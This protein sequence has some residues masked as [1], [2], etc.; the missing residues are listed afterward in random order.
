[1]STP[2]FTAAS[3]VG[4]NFPRP[5][6]K[7]PGVQANVANP[8]DKVEI[9]LSDNTVHTVVDTVE[10]ALKCMEFMRVRDQWLL[11]PTDDI[12]I[13]SV[14]YVKLLIAESSLVNQKLLSTFMPLYL[15]GSTRFAH[16]S[17]SVVQRLSSSLQDVGF[18]VQDAF[19]D[20][21][22]LQNP[23]R[24]KSPHIVIVDINFKANPT[25]LAP[26]SVLDDG[27]NLITYKY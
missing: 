11:T 22:Q 2:I 26:G 10:T 21:F 23:V 12:M 24:G 19:I 9:K 25:A 6:V 20:N 3:F 14:S 13:F 1:M 8:N 4:T 15:G 5:Y 27:D 17:M 18:C 7:L 16:R